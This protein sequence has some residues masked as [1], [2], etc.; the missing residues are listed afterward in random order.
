VYAVY[1]GNRAASV[2]NKIAS[3]MEMAFQ[4]GHV[5]GNTFKGNSIVL[6]LNALV[7]INF[8]PTE[9]SIS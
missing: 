9:S 7:A 3:L 4:Y 5:V 2:H 8:A 6:S 1:C